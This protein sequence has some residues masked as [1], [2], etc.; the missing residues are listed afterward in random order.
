MN[1]KNYFTLQ[2]TEL[3]IS[4]LCI[5]IFSVGVFLHILPQFQEFAYSSTSPLL[6]FFDAASLICIAVVLSKKDKTVFFAWLLIAYSISF[7]AE[8]LGV[9][10]GLIFGAYRYSDVL[11]Y[12]FLNVP[13]VI[14]LNWCVL[15]LAGYSFLSRF[16]KSKMAIVIFNAL[17]LSI[18]DFFMEPVAIGLN[19]WQ[20]EQVAV[21][22]QNY[23]AWFL[24][25]LLL[26][27]MLI[28]A[29]LRYRALFAESYLFIQMGFFMALNAMFRFQIL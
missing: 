21:P 20:W 18:F 4:L 25:S 17:L 5:V 3:Y 2:K 14:G 15:V 13:V 9:K 29:K 26:T 11:G 28:L 6:F 23:L 7:S 1:T 16:I 27:F 24:I 19:Y 8:A 12:K 22:L 10:T